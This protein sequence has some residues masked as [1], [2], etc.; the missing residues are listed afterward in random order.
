VT[1]KGHF[2][3]DIEPGDELLVQATIPYGMA[4]SAQVV[5]DSAK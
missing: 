4:V 5:K 3:V 2:Q 1:F